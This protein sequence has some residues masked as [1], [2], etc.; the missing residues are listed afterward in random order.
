M[1][2]KKQSSYA[3]YRYPGWGLIL[4]SLLIL[5]A[6][7]EKAAYTPPPP[8]QV[9]VS[10]PLRQ[11]ITDYLESTGNTQAIN[12][13]Q[14]R[15]RVEGYLEKV[16]FQDGDPIKKGQLLFLI[17]QNTYLA[18]LQQA[19]AA[20]ISQKARLVHAQTELVRY[21]KLLKQKA[22]SQTDVDQWQYERDSARGA[23]LA[24]QAQR[25]LAKLD[26][27]YTRVTAPFNG[28]IDRRLKDPGN[29][30]GSGE[31]TILAEVNQIDPIYVYFT[32]NERDLLHLMGGTKLSPA[33]ASKMKWPVY[34]GLATEKGYPHQG[35]LDFAAISVTRTT[36]TLLLRG[37]ASNPKGIVLPG[38]YARVRVPVGEKK[39]ALLVP[40]A[41]LGFDQQGP[42][43][44]V[45]NEKNL[46]E[47]RAVTLGA[48]ADG[49]RV[50]A[51]GLEGQEL[52][53]VEGVIKAIPGR[54]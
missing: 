38:L 30:V 13:V 2:Q 5:A 11:T 39:D 16:L 52:V 29:L 21:T 9:T 46:V 27:S 36:G 42:Y 15:A 18:K 48:E 1:S 54:P 20:I 50:I 37:I 3:S 34:F 19:E 31:S 33:A 8:P 26:V 22:A 4:I 43:V 51:E 32:I 17:Q 28:R 10:H 49:F 35:R 24:A 14:L 12:T 6:C 40:V 45:V 23:L 41:A 53:V 7:G 25:D 47:R 44:L